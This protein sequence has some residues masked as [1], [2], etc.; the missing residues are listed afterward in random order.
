MEGW[1]D[2]VH[3]YDRKAHKKIGWLT[4]TLTGGFRAID[5]ERAARRTITYGI[6][7]DESYADVVQQAIEDL[8]ELLPKARDLDARIVERKN[9]QPHER[10]YLYEPGQK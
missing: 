5:D 3:E 8:K 4:V 9:Q 1:Q 10:K 7:P 2:I 6:D